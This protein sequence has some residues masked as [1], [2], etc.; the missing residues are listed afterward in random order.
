MNTIEIRAR[1][2]EEI[3]HCDDRLLKMIFAIINEYKDA[4]NLDENRKQLVIEERAKY[5]KGEGKSYSWEEVKKIALSKDRP[6]D[7]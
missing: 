5:L 6:N 7:F 2:H 3:E 1:L 4:D